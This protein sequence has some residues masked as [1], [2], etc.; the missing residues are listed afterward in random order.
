MRLY[1]L[2]HLGNIQ[3]IYK[4]IVFTA[5]LTI[6]H[7]SR[8]FGE[9]IAEM[10][11]VCTHPHYRGQGMCHIILHELEKVT[12]SVDY[13]WSFEGWNFQSFLQ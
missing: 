3:L 10:P 5:V 1:L 4:K 12:L 13:T 8:V 7:L 11:L 2:P 6:C 9:K